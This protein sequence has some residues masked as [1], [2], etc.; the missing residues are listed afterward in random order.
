VCRNCMESVLYLASWF[1]LVSGELV[2][3]GILVGVGVSDR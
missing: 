3:D 2:S 1:R